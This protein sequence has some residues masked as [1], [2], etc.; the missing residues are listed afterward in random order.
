[1]TDVCG[2]STKENP[3]IT[4]GWNIAASPATECMTSNVKPRGKL[5]NRIRNWY[6]D[7]QVVRKEMSTHWTESAEMHR[8]SCGF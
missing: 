7:L 4:Q 2:R 8:H 3:C 6:R 1:M 5:T